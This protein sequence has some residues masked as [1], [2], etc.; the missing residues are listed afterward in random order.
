MEQ[1]ILAELI[2]LE[3]LRHQPYLKTKM[4]CELR[5]FTHHLCEESRLSLKQVSTRSQNFVLPVCRAAPRAQKY[6]S[7][8]PKD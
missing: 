7:N 5:K 2:T 4:V 1:D 8:P 3:M 6:F